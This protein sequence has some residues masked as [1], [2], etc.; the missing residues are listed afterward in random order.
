MSDVDV[1]RHDLY[2]IGS[3]M[4]VT[5]KGNSLWLKQWRRGDSTTV[6]LSPSESLTLGIRLVAFAHANEVEKLITGSID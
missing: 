1:K 5:T 2:E 6:R 3:S 4:E